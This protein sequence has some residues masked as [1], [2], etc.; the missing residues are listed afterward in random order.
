MG[1]INQIKQT[2]HHPNPYFSNDTIWAPLLAIDYTKYLVLPLVQVLA[3]RGSFKTWSLHHQARFGL[4]K[5]LKRNVT[6]DILVLLKSKQKNICRYLLITLVGLRKVSKK[7]LNEK[8]NVGN[9]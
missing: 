8:Y 2:I 4:T 1:K 6:S 5:K 3:G 9:F 7:K